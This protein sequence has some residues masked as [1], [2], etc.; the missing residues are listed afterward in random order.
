MR[1][2]TPTASRQQ[3]LVL[4]WQI[5][6]V[7]P[8]GVKLSC[9]NELDGCLD[10]IHLLRDAFGADLVAFV[11]DFGASVTL[12]L[13]SL[14]P[15]HEAQAF[16][17]T[18]YSNFGN[19]VMS[20]ELGHQMGCCHALGDG[21]GCDDGGLFPF[22]N[23]HRFEGDSGTLWKTIMAYNPGTTVLRF[24][25]PWV[26]ADGQPTGV[27]QSEPDSADNVATIDASALM[28]SNYRCP[29][30][31]SGSHLASSTRTSRSAIERSRRTVG[32]A[33]EEC[34]RPVRAGE[35]HAGCG[36]A[37]TATPGDRP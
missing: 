11:D 33:I 13:K 12:G 1:I 10:Q 26:S 37:G 16:A 19:T 34:V 14:D 15:A 9:L 5:D 18:P 25:N 2:G 22:S 6:P 8:T 23:G 29:G 21:G 27:P 32:T 24:S 4:A 17:L 28:V 30:P 35:G 36:E 3:R 31:C 20:H 7:S